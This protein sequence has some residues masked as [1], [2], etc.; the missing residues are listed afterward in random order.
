ME[1]L[2]ELFQ[3]RPVLVV[4]YIG[5]LII[6]ISSLVVYFSKRKQEKGTFDNVKPQASFTLENQ[7]QKIADCDEVDVRRF[8]NNMF[9]NPEQFVILTS[10]KVQNKVRYI[11]ACMRNEQVEVEIA[12]QEQRTRLYYKLCTKGECYAIFYDF[13]NNEFQPNMSEYHPLELK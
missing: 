2:V 1:W 11:Q 4:R 9:D 6:I 5:T 7:N 3:E 8:L 10:P 13:I 12:I